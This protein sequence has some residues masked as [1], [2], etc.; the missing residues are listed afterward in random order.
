M[1]P[2]FCV[3][4]K[5]VVQPGQDERFI[6]SW[7]ELTRR[8]H[9][10]CGSLGSRLHRIDG[11]VYI[12]YAQ[13]PTRETWEEARLTEGQLGDLRAEMRACCESVETRAT[14]DV[15]EDFLKHETS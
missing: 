8:I 13:W 2:T 12:A 15:V 5:F 4:Y 11:S 9:E 6:A 10:H 3:I 1:K 7:K 14:L